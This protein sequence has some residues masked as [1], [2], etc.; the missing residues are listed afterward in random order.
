MTLSTQV[1]QSS[2]CR[3]VPSVE[4]FTLWAETA[5]SSVADKDS[6][7][8]IR[9]V[10]REEGAE[11]NRKYR[12]GEGATNVLSFTYADGPFS[13]PDLLGDIVIC[14]PVVEQ[15]AIQQKKV[16][17]A[18]WAHLVV[19]GILHLCGYNHID[20]KD[21]GAMEQ[22]ESEILCQLGFAEPYG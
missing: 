4:H 14:A 7:V 3:K 6:K 19:H 9:I 8:T 18:H 5:F 1:Q 16:L 22:L 11:L 2:E 12:K 20:Q 15:E 10:D 21:A 13:P 17:D